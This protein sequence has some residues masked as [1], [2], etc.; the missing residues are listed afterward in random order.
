M[1]AT[2][3]EQDATPLAQSSQA[4]LSNDQNPHGPWCGW[5]AG[6]PELE[7]SVLGRTTMASTDAALP[8][9]VEQGLVDPGE[10]TATANYHS[11]SIPINQIEQTSSAIGLVGKAPVD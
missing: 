4:R 2:E 11:G 6:R 3:P 10:G 9:P 8:A 1:D 5:L 7:D